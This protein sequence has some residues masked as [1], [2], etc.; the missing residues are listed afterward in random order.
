MRGIRS[1]RTWSW[2]PT[3]RPTC[4]SVERSSG[5]RSFRIP[6]QRR[7]WQRGLGETLWRYRRTIFNPRFGSFGLLAL[8]HFLLFEFLG[9]IVEVF[10]LVVVLVAWLLGVLSLSFFLAFLTVSILLSVLLSIAA[11]L[12]EEYAVRRHERSSDV[13][14]LVLYGVLENFGYRQLT[15]FWRCRGALDLVRGRKEWGEM[16]RRG[17]ERRAE[18]PL[19]R[20]K[21]RQ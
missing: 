8:P 4:A 13:A 15:A 18:V 17:L 10:G 21:A 16:P 6:S 20:E 1:G 11:I 3:C 7:R 19:P 2:W 9:A 5:S 14:L 12:L